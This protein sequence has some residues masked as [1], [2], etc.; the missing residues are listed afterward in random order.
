LVG[1][2]GFDTLVGGGGSDTFRIDS[3]DQGIDRIL[4][5]QAGSGGDVLDLRTLLDFGGSGDVG[6]FVQLSPSGGDTE[7]RADPDGAGGNFTPVLNLL[8][9]TGLEVGNLVADGNLLA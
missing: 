7:V 6:S 4:D 1:G 9:V 3:L 2:Y 5:F 8:G